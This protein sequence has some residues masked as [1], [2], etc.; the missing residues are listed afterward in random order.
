M[1]KS[2]P[3]QLASNAGLVTISDNI[4]GERAQYQIQV[5]VRVL[6]SYVY[7]VCRR[8][9]VC[10]CISMFKISNPGMLRYRVLQ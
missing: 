6:V 7:G 3:F 2:S 5:Q 1:R 4:N 9:Q 10:S 8:K